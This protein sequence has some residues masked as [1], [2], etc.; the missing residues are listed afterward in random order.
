MADPSADLR[1]FLSHT[2]FFGGLPEVALDQL[3]GMLKEK[4][5][6]AGSEVFHEGDKGCSM[7]VVREG[8]LIACRQGASGRNVRLVHY[9]P[10]DFFGETTLIEMQPRPA[11]VV[12]EQEALV[13]ELSNGALY[14]LYQQDLKAYV[15]ILQNI[16][17]ELCRRLRKA[18][19]R[20]TQKADESGD[21]ITQISK[22]N[23]L[24]GRG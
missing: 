24:P 22:V 9:V 4:R 13:Y 14:R 15:L 12:A 3:I 23:P 7:Y 17:R 6:A 1:E 20:V 16:N 2:P 8:N 18:E 21:E 10:G 19:G 11:S 5:V